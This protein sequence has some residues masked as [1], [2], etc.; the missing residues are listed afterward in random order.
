MNT[1]N[2]TIILGEISQNKEPIKQR[3]LDQ[4]AG[5]SLGMT[6]VL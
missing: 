4:I 2:E 6:N 3:E 1:E 5:L